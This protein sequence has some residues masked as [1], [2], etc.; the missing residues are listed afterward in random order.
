MESDNLPLKPGQRATSQV[1]LPGP[2]TLTDLLNYPADLLKPSAGQQ[3][4]LLASKNP[5]ILTKQA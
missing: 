3:N 4:N 2:L 1:N 5:I